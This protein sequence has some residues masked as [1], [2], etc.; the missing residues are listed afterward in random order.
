M[1]FGD[2]PFGQ[3]PRPLAEINMIPLIDVML[4]LLIVFMI[5]APLLTHRVG[6][7]LPQA[8]ST[9]RPPVTD[10]I[11]LTIQADGA[12]FWNAAPLTEAELA[13]RM[14]AAATGVPVPELHL[15]ADRRVPYGQVA[16]VIALAARSGLTHI[17]FVTE[18]RPLP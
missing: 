17:G 11:R 4:V 12:L 8:D 3:A 14:T 1:S 7:E 13:E 15:Q 9:P 16:A 2:S 5:T 6:L 18:P 10:A